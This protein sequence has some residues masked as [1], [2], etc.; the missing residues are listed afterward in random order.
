[1]TQHELEQ[2][3]ER[4]IRDEL[5][6]EDRMKAEAEARRREEAEVRDMSCSNPQPTGLC[7]VSHT[8]NIQ[9]CQL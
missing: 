2:R 1:V 4:R 7:C 6:Q 9:L 8:F 5:L 3:E